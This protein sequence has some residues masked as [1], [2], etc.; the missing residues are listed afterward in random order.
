MY[1]GPS[2]VLSDVATSAAV[3]VKEIIIAA[4]KKKE[5]RKAGKSYSKKI[6]N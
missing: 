2:F 6:K 4:E 1:F 3:S 5:K